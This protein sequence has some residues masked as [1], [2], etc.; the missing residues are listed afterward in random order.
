MAKFV[1]HTRSRVDRY[2]R[3][4]RRGA[5]GRPFNARISSTRQLRRPRGPRPRSVRLRR[6]DEVIEQVVNSSTLSDNST[7]SRSHDKGFHENCL[8]NRTSFRSAH[9]CRLSGG[10]SGATIDTEPKANP[11][12]TSESIPTASNT[13]DPTSR[14]RQVNPARLRARSTSLAMTDGARDLELREAR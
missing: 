8:K 10:A 1:A 2:P 14:N 5:P 12:H 7:N 9:A 4:P 13:A 3:P 11:L 6:P